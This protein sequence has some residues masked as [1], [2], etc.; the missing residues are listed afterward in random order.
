MKKLTV[1]CDFDDVLINFCEV[2]V[3]LI[4]E[5]NGTF[6][7]ISDI[8]EWE[9]AKF[10]PN[11]T[12]EQIYKPLYEGEIWDRVVPLPGAVD[13]LRKIMEDGHE[14]Y[15]VTSSHYKTIAT[16]IEKVLLKYF[17][18][19]NPSDVLVVNKKKM[20]IGDVLIDDGEHNLKGGVYK[21]ILMNQ[22]HNESFDA[23]EAGFIRVHN[24]EETY[25]VI[26]KIAKGE[27]DETN[28]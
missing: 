14:V 22:P 21:G 10:F 5:Q 6:I 8:K 17:P 19:F 23:D 11:L 18:Y 12:H 1:L 27:S 13:Y 26:N 4:N 16:K 28:S 3:Q 20:V 9:I 15:I 2:W 7:H 25:D 24:W